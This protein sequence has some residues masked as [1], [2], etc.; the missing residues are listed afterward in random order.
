ME[1]IQGTVWQKPG[2]NWPGPG[3]HGPAIIETVRKRN[4]CSHWNQAT[5]VQYHVRQLS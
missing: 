2:P 3:F 4:C 5:P 1:L